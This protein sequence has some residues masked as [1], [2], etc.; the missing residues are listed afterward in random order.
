MPLPSFQ[1]NI[2]G[3]CVGWEGGAGTDASLTD[4]AGTSYTR[5]TQV[6][7]DANRDIALFT[8]RVPATPGTITITATIPAGA[9]FQGLYAVELAGITIAD[10]LDVATS[11][12]TAFSLT[13]TQKNDVI[14]ACVQGNLSIAV[15]SIENLGFSAIIS[16][17]TTTQDSGAIAYTLQPMAGPIY[18]KIFNTSSATVQGNMA[19]KTF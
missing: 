19:I 3:V 5:Q 14:L 10:T 6:T 7:G 8:G 1:N 11:G 18:T 15:S 9:G 16:T 12:F 2:L 13:T 4:S 17:S